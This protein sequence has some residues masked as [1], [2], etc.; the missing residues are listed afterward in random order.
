MGSLPLV[1]VDKHA[2]I[3]SFFCEQALSIL[4]V[5]LL[6]VE[7]LSDISPLFFTGMF[8]VSF[9]CLLSQ[10]SSVLGFTI[11]TLNCFNAGHCCCPLYEY[12]HSWFESVV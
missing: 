3:L 12:I 10:Q 9:M 7:K 11:C 5:S 4:S 6:A 8:E 1:Y 2:L